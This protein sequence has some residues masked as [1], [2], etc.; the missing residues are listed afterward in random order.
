MVHALVEDQSEVLPEVDV[1]TLLL[2]TDGDVRA[3]VAV[4]K[5][6]HAMMPRSELV[7]LRGPG[8][9]SC[10]EAPDEVTRVLR[11]FLHSAG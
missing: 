7:V 5:A 4:G 10:V 11:R 3:P 8:H 6:I 2:Y 1:P 9:V